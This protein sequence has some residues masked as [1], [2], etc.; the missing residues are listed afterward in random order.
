MEDSNPKNTLI[1]N[2]HVIDPANQVDTIADV[3][4]V[5]GK[6]EAVEANLV[7][8]DDKL[9]VEEFDARGLVVTPGLIDCH[10]HV[11]EHA[12]VLGLNPDQY[13]LSRGVTTVVDAGSAG[14]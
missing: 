12:T 13:C 6:I 4:I 11:Y 8:P 2:G 3:L 7:I 10:V 14:D 9:K 5:N 1:R